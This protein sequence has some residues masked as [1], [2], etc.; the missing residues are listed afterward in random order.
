LEKQ[1]YK[2]NF[3]ENL[4][5][6][7][8]VFTQVSFNLK[9]TFPA[10]YASLLVFLVPAVLYQDKWNSLSTVMLVVSL[11]GLAVNVVIGSKVNILKKF[12]GILHPIWAYATIIAFGMVSRLNLVD[13]ILAAGFVVFGIIY[14][15]IPSAGMSN[16]IR[17]ILN[18]VILANSGDTGARICLRVKRKDEI[19]ILAENLNSFFEERHNFIKMLQDNASQLAETSRELDGISESSSAAFRQI[20]AAIDQVAK[21][22]TEQAKIT[23]EAVGVMGQVGM[24]IEQIA[25]GAQEQ[26][27]NVVK[28]TEMVN[29]MTVKMDKMAAGMEIVR[30]VSQQNGSLA[31]NGGKS[32]NKTV[33]GMNR[34]RA[35]VLETSQ[36]LNQLG[37]RSQKI[38]EIIQVIDDIAEQTNLLALNAAI[39]AARAGE[40]GKG[41]AVVADEVRK[42]AERS[43]KATK[44]I[45]DLITDIQKRTKTA[46]DSMEKGT[47]EASEGVALAEEAGQALSEIVNGVVTAAENVGK[48]TDTI[49][50]IMDSSREVSHAVNNVAA[51]TEENSAATQQISASSEQVNG[52]IKNVASISQENAA[53]VE[54]VSASTEELAGSID[55]ISTSAKG[56]TRMAARMQELVNQFR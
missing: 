13:W 50:E 28:T 32:V 36:N 23:N 17:S 56:L 25:V 53:S 22:S 15:W 40:H 46:V 24:S 38:G 47:R 1:A 39:E 26:S 30:E 45:A 5:L 27:G 7:G 10:I 9:Y 18:G 37:E 29:E 55:N 19:G 43:G 11:A 31:Q 14:W 6:E 44:E 48:I 3:L 20:A 34:V 8:H 21:G 42:L 4:G 41:F 51:I 2:L 33:E 12:S 54:E 52:T 49:N 16:A 35:A